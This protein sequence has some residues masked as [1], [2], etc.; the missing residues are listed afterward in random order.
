MTIITKTVTSRRQ[1]KK[2][3]DKCY[4]ADHQGGLNNNGMSFCGSV[5][6]ANA[7]KEGNYFTVVVSSNYYVESSLEKIIN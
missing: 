3:I 1:A 2:I 4:N 7:T 5:I 6:T